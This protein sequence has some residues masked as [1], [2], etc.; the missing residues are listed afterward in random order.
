MMGQAQ[1]HGHDH[2]DNGRPNNKPD[3]VEEAF[4]DYP[5]NVAPVHRPVA[6]QNPSGA[7]IRGRGFYPTQ[8]PEGFVPVC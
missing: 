3:T 4:E 1:N 2:T 7:V 6:F 8:R 5:R